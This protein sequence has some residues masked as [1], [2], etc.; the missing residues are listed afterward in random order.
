MTE[1]NLV[2]K[3]TTRAFVEDHHIVESCSVGQPKYESRRHSCGKEKDIEG[4]WSSASSVNQSEAPPDMEME[5]DGIGMAS[6]GVDD[7]GKEGMA[8][9]SVITVVFILTFSTVSKKLSLSP[10]KSDDEDKKDDEKQYFNFGEVI[11]GNVYRSSFP[12][13]EDYQFLQSLG[14]KTIV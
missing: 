2:S 11:T 6:Y 4:K 9:I 10:P 1:G 12:R 14:L 5:S 8:C 13:T 7:L 3:R